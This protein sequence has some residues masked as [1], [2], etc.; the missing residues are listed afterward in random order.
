MRLEV[1]PQPMGETLFG[2]RGR[3]R[4]AKLD[5]VPRTNTPHNQDKLTVANSAK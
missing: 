4:T 3:N 1:I 2:R 5:D